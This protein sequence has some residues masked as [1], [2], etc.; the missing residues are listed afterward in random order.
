MLFQNKKTS[1]FPN[2]MKLH[3]FVGSFFQWTFFFW[4]KTVPTKPSNLNPNPASHP[5]TEH[6][7]SRH[8]SQPSHP[9]TFSELLGKSRFLYWSVDKWCLVWFCERILVEDEGHKGKKTYSWVANKVLNNLWDEVN[10][11]EEGTT[12]SAFFPPPFKFQP[13]KSEL[14]IW[15]NGNLVRY[16]GSLWIF[17][18]RYCWERFRIIPALFETAFTT[19]SCNRNRYK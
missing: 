13:R 4:N 12:E 1:L 9:P 8:A 2:F 16:P 11:K 15:W 18:C 3:E 19:L 6:L 14:Q 5:A 7:Q 17:I 10:N